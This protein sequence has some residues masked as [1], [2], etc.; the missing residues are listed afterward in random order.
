MEAPTEEESG[1]ELDFSFELLG[2][3]ILL[4]FACVFWEWFFGE[5][6]ER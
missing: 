4:F 3:I 6:S 5:I 2:N 1:G